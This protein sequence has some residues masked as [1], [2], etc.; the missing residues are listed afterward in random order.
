MFTEFIGW[1]LELTRKCNLACPACPRTYDFDKMENPT[2]SLDTKLI[3]QFFHDREKIKN[4]KYMLFCGNLGDP[5]YHKDFHEISEHFFDVE[6]LWVNTNGMHKKSFWKRVLKTWPENGKI[7]LAIDGL[8]DTNHLYRVNSK[9]EKIQEL[10]DLISSTKRKCKIEWK[11]IVF[12]HNHHQIDEAHDLSKKLGIDFFNIQKTRKLDD[13]K[14]ANGF[15]KEYQIDDYFKYKNEYEDYLVPFCHTG[16]LH[17]INAEGYYSPCCWWPNFNRQEWDNFHI[18]NYNMN[19]IK[20]KFYKF[21]REK[22]ENDFSLAPTPCK[23]AC[24]K[25]KNNNNDFKIP[26]SQ[27]NRKILKND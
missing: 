21:S 14:N 15:L 1:H 8:K 12:E 10:F 23:M 7:I 11:Y 22:L 27:I 24:R 18:S 4:L 2:V 17:Y 9:W 3:K 16:D 20:E 19:E 5:I 6:H 13:K 26:N 25:V